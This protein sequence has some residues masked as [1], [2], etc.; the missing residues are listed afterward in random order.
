MT[1]TKTTTVGGGTLTVTPKEKPYNEMQNLFAFAAIKNDGSVVTWGNTELV[2]DGGFY[3]EVRTDNFPYIN[4]KKYSVANQLDGKI[5]VTQIYSTMTAFAA[6]RADGSVV[7]WGSNGG[8]SSA[9]KDKLNGTVDVT[10]IYSNGGAFTALRADGSVVVWGSETSGG[11][12]N[13]YHYDEAS[14]AYTKGDSVLKQLDGSVKIIQI[15]STG[16]T[17]DGVDIGFGS[18]ESFAALREDG[19]V[20]AWGDTGE[21]SVYSY[22]AEGKIYTKEF[23][24]NNP[25]NGAIKTVK[26][27]SDDGSLVALR[28]DNSIVVWGD[29]D[30]IPVVN[31]LVI[32]G[33][34]PGIVK[35]AVNNVSNSG[36]AL[37]SDGSL[38]NFGDDINSDNLQTQLDDTVKLIQICSNYYTE[39]GGTLDP[40][41]STGGAIISN[42]PKGAFVF[43]Q[44]DGSVLTL[45]DAEFGGDGNVYH[46]DSTSSQYIKDYSVSEKIDGRIKVQKIYSSGLSPKTN[47]L[48]YAGAAVVLTQGVAL[49]VIH[50]PGAAFAALRE[51]GSVITWGDAN[52]GGDSSLVSEQLNGSIK[53]KEIYSNTGA[54]AALREDGS[55]VTWG[56]SI[57]GGDSRLYHAI[58][59]SIGYYLANNNF[60][61]DSTVEDKL[62]GSVKVTEIHPVMFRGF[63]ALR[64]DGTAVF[65]GNLMN[66]DEKNINQ[67][68]ASSIKITKIHTLFDAPWGDFG[69]YA[70]LREDGSV[71]TWGDNGQGSAIAD[72]L[73]SGVVAFS[74]PST[75]DFYNVPIISTKPTS[76]NDL[77]TGSTNNDK[78][79]ALAGD[80]TITGG[81]GSDKL[82]GGKGVDVFRYTDIKDSGTTATTRDT[83]TDFKHSEGDKIDLSAIDANAKLAS[84]QAF[85]FIGAK[86]FS[87]TDATGQLRFDATA[88][89]LY[90]STNA[91]SKPEF[92]ILLSGVKALVVDDFVL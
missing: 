51:D 28:E 11:D 33:T 55:V 5:P 69:G 57:Q 43:L 89:V 67:Q 6:L 15:Y 7:A 30:G 72:K 3:V 29:N 61:S 20:V 25:L 86:A 66:A 19:S 47:G 83:I 27:Y 42:E 21:M 78:L 9:V 36:V 54:F 60:E 1:T 64:E 88:H 22:D 38:E 37:G 74:D 10:K 76:G 34:L 17:I 23:F 53:V 18:K 14:F 4:T 45:G 12:G 58:P 65:W 87:K 24:L 32:N 92:S 91:D 26:I 79:S 56:D 2:G 8:D 16:G 68:L 80:D 31:R 90:G 70:A 73:K 52:E 35:I 82:T 75:D 77:L 50:Q 63:V 40:T 13:I 71:I 41:G 46:Y 62:N 81:L 49:P 84:N 59:D 44:E 85:T 39:R 48:H